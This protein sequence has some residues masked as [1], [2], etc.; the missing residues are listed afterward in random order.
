[1]PISRR[2]MRSSFRCVRV[3]NRLH[4]ACLQ[5]TDFTDHRLATFG[6]YPFFFNWNRRTENVTICVRI[7]SIRN[8][9][10]FAVIIVVAGDNVIVIGIT[11]PVFATGAR[12]TS[13]FG[14]GIGWKFLSQTFA[15]TIQHFLNTLISLLDRL[16]HTLFYQVA[17]NAPDLRRKEF[18]GAGVDASV[19]IC[20]VGYRRNV[21]QTNVLKRSGNEPVTAFILRILPIVTVISFWL[22]GERTLI[23]VTALNCSMKISVCLL[24]GVKL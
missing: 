13:C 20:R 10:I 3:G 21:K 5:R 8:F 9:D 6:R 22:E 16:L 18:V 14:G 19:L 7:L 2:L 17:H 23:Y 11:N 4:V 24:I 12:L 1:M 15:N